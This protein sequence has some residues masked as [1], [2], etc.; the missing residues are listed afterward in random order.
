MVGGSTRGHQH[1]SS[2]K[3]DQTHWIAY[4]WRCLVYDSDLMPKL[5]RELEAQTL[6]IVSNFIWIDLGASWPSKGM[7]LSVLLMQGI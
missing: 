1:A 2:Q 4:Q 7:Y 6:A 5:Q 3:E